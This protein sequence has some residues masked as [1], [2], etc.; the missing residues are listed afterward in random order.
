ME[1][2]IGERREPP[3]AFVPSARLEKGQTPAPASASIL[4]NGEKFP[5]RSVAVPVK[6]DNKGLRNFFWL[7]PRKFKGERDLFVI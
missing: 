6:V 4:S 2:R 5:E 1:R 7:Y 3:V